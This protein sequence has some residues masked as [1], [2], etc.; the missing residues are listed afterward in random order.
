MEISALWPV[1]NRDTVVDAFG[2]DMMEDLKVVIFTRSV[3]EM[4]GIDLP[5]LNDSERRASS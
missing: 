1:S 2:V 4:P 5:P 3:E